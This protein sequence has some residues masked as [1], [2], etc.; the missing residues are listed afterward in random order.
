MSTICPV[1]PKQQTFTNPVGTSYLCHQRKCP[2]SNATVQPFSLALVELS[3]LSVFCPIKSSTGLSVAW[4]GLIETLQQRRQPSHAAQELAHAGPLVVVGLR[5]QPL[6]RR[7]HFVDVRRDPFRRYG[8]APGE[9]QV[10]DVLDEGGRELG[11][12]LVAIG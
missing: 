11:A 4:Y 10:S 6:H 9:P 7:Q 1:Y 3:W 8:V 5:I 12:H 2:S